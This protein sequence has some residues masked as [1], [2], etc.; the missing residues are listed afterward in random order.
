[1]NVPRFHVHFSGRLWALCRKEALQILRDPSSNLIAFVLPLVMLLIFGYGIN[2]DTTRIKV[3]LVIQD[4]SPDARQLADSF[5]GSPY[6]SVA[7]GRER[8]GM[9]E[10]LAAGKIRGLIVIPSDFTARLDRP[11]EVA[12]LQ[13]LTDG[14]EPNIAAFVENYSRGIWQHWLDQRARTHGQTIP[15]E[16]NL[17]ARVWF[18][19]SA[20]SRN[21]LIPGSITL[22]MTVVGA[23]LTSLVVAREWERGTMEALLSTPV[24]RGEIL[25][26]KLIPYY[27]LG[28]MSLVVCM[29]VA[30]FV[31]RVPFRGSISVLFVVASLFL[32]CAL[33]L[34]LLL[35]TVT[36]NQ[37]NAAQ[38]ALNAAF[39]PAM[40]LSGFIYEITSMPAPLRAVTYLI[41]ARYFVA[42][43][44]T[45]FQAG[46]V[47]PILIP[48]LLFLSA[49]AVFFL[50]MTAIK[51]RR[52]LE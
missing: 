41:P 12:P 11:G 34:G 14:A 29:L 6:L 46:D 16:I 48:N 51:T 31:L 24:T 9:E 21:Y 17:E 30:V 39:L 22:I 50:G 18:N 26:S 37:F 4:S 25:L 38:G 10:A 33:G 47:W 49:A 2:L 3:G 27:V 32:L 42:S 35:S 1:M 13:V 52:S 40:M 5:F 28:M 36:R 8:G 43:M 15:E 23:L 7:T 19:P 44:Q 20:E 45:L